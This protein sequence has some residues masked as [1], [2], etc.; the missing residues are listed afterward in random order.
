M[1]ATL[2]FGSIL[3]GASGT[4]A[5]DIP[6]DRLHVD[7]HFAELYGLPAVELESDFPTSVFFQAIH[8]DDRSRIRIAVA[9][10]LAGAELFTKDFRVI[11]PGGNTLWMHGR[12]Q[13]HLDDNDQPVRFTGLLVD[14]TERKRAE[15]KLR[16]AQSAG[17]IGSF[18]YIDGFATASV[19]DEFCRVLGL[20]P[21]SVLPV[22]TINGLL[23]DA[24]V[25]LIPGPGDGTV[26]D[27]VDREFCIRRSSDGALRW[28]ARRGE[29]MREGAGYRLVGVIYDITV[30]KEQEAELR[31]WSEKLEA[32]VEEEVAVRH[33]AEDALR[34]AQKMEA[35]G[36]LT[37]GIA[38]DFNNLLMAITSSLILLRKR[39]PSDPAT[40]RLI[41]GAMQGAERGASLTQRM[42]AFAR[43]QDLTTRPL[44]MAVVVEGMKEL[45]TRTLGPAWSLE[46]D[47]S[48]QLPSVMA[49]VNQIEMA[50]LNLTV[51]A[52]DAMPTGGP[53]TIEARLK[54][55]AHLE[56]SQL[57]PGAYIAIS[58]IDR[59]T[60]MDKA[61]LERA[62]EP[63]FTTKGVGK[64]TGLGLSMI[65]GL[66]EQLGGGFTLESTLGVG[67]RATL[68]LP[69]APLE[70]GLTNPA[71]VKEAIGDHA[72]SL[73]VL[74]V[75]DDGLILMNTADLL[76]DLGHQVLEAGSGE[77]A[78]EML[79]QDPGIDVL[80]TDHAMPG[81][82]GSQL[83]ELVN[84]ERSDLPIILAS[85]YGD[86][87]GVGNRH[88]IK[89]GKPF[90]Q[91]M[92]AQALRDAIDMI[93][94][95]V[96]RED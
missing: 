76:E 4:W 20:H 61:T 51:N 89:L 79:R 57:T 44:D 85:G 41:D 10:M 87:A 42:L 65:H 54:E 15:E 25:P 52:R 55:H 27:T 48:P 28:I 75:D 31:S 71:P 23:E 81:M 50:I 2:P 82:T 56:N 43:R 13:C 45:V 24:S 63:F 96:L 6:G 92:L 86:L 21:T 90:T 59:G 16:I 58:V 91:D 72:P 32:R 30:A 22:Q 11:T 66:A 53:I 64:G 36:Q 8:P 74:A 77:E 84:L 83:A 68:W 46:L 1:R 33:K 67:T 47:V 93:P 7:E 70:H 26:P 5:W 12:G 94:R 95:A 18:E 88:L 29:I 14:I 19:S 17:G 62:T 69:L 38:H 37:G 39:I 80:I 9:G 35:V 49:D 40:D 73:K 3:S 34:Q 60:G 78:L